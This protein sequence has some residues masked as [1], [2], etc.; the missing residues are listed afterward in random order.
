MEDKVNVYNATATYNLSLLYSVPS[1]SKLS[2]CFIERCFSIVA[3]SHNFKELDYIAVVKILSSNELN[4]DSELQVF[5]AADAWLNFNVEQRSKFSKSILI[6]IRL[7][8]LSDHVLRYLSKVSS[9]YK[10]EEFVATINELLHNK[11]NMQLNRTKHFNETRFCSQNKFNMLLCGGYDCRDLKEVQ[12][13]ILSI[14]FKNLNNAKSIR[15][16]NI[17]RY[18]SV[19]V[20]IKDEVYL[21]GGEHANYRPIMSIEKYSFSNNALEKVGNMND[22]RTEF[23]ACSFLDYIYIIEG[24]L[25]G[26]ATNSCVTFDSKSRI[27]KDVSVMNERRKNVACAVFEGQVVVSGGWNDRGIG[28]RLK[29]VKVYDHV[30]D[31]WSYND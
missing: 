28:N 18:G 11:K 31:S 4:L 9:T 14:D 22:D 2:L 12:G 10:N 1:L 21:F 25:N 5:T 26:Y 30:A 23:C 6:Y 20:C 16:M 19:A 17:G 8:L 3:D 15:K 24:H 27:W 29:T 13:N 7:P